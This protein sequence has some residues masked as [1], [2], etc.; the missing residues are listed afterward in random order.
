VLPLAPGCGMKL[1]LVIASF[2][3]ISRMSS[4]LPRAATPAT[5]S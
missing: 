1:N 3:K 4:K 2:E 5:T